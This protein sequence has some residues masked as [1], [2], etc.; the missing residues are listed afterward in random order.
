MRQ[1]EIVQNWITNH[2]RVADPAGVDPD[3]YPT[4]VETGSGSDFINK[5]DVD[6]IF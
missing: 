4:L 2:F 5:P 6:A 1:T 3:K